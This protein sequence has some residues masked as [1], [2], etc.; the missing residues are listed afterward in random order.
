M[1]HG[2]LAGRLVLDRRARAAQQSTHPGFQLQNV[3]GLCNIVVRA[4]LKA[5]D[6]IGVLAAGGEHDNGHIGKLPDTHAGLEPVDLGHHQVQDNEVE[7]ALP[8]Q[9]HRL[10]TVVAGLH[11]IALIF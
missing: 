1:A 2:E 6:F 9:L 8:G 3:E 5:D 4:A 11:L 7:L 10:L